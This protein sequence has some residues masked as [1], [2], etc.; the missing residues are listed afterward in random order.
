MQK[1][2]WVICRSGYSSI[3]DLAVVGQKAILVPTPGQTEQEYLAETVQAQHF[4]MAAK[5]EGFSLKAELEKAGKFNFKQVEIAPKNLKTAVKS[6]V[7]QI[8]L[9]KKKES[10]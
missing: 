10:N 2:Q 7:E 6:F 4:F 1:A 3:M 5:Q 9:N 8:K